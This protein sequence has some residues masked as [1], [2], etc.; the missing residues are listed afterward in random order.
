MADSF[1]VSHLIE[2]FI[3]MDIKIAQVDRERE[4]IELAFHGNYGQWRMIVG[5]Q[6]SGNVR[7]L[8]FVVP[9][10]AS[11]GDKRRQECLEALMVVNYRIAMGKF[12]L[13]LEDGEVRLEETVPLADNYLSYGQ[14]QLVFGAIIQTVAIYHNLLPRI[15]HT[16]ATILEVIRACEQEFFQDEAGFSQSTGRTPLLPSSLQ[17]SENAD[18]ETD[19]DVNDVLAEVTRL[20]RQSRN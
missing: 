5:F 7:K 19:L 4:V 20:L 14:F 13:D 12:G 10:I 11:I 17:Q 16:D 8:M 6:Q 2:Y 15:M 18:E 9:Q 3:K 1:G